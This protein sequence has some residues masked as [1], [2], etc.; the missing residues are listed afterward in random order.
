MRTQPSNFYAVFAAAADRFSDR[1]A[2]E[3]QTTG[4][5]LQVRYGDLK[6]LAESTAGWLVSR[7][8][9][10]GDR[11]AVLADNDAHWCAAY[12]GILRCG[13]VAVPLDTAYTDTQ[14]A[15]LF[16]DCSA[17]A[18][19]TSS[20]YLASVH[21]GATRASIAPCIAVLPPVGHELDDS[22]VAQGGATSFGVVASQAALAFDCPAGRDD[23]AV[24]LYTSGTTSDPKGVVLTHANLLAERE[25]AFRIVSV[26]EADAVLSV[27]PLFHA[28]AQMA[29]LLLPLS[30]GARVVF[31]ETVN[32]TELTRA[33]RERGITAFVCVPQFFYLL[34][35]RIE[36]GI[37][38]LAAPARAAVRML[39]RI[40]LLSRRVGVNAGRVLFRRIHESVGPDL[41]V[42][43]TGGARFDPATNRALHALGFTIQQAYGLTE[44]SGAATVTRQ[45]DL[46]FDSVGLPFPGVELRIGPPDEA[47]ADR[48][49]GEVLIRGPIVMKGYYNRPDE[50][51]RTLVDGWLYTGDLGYLDAN[52]RLYITGRSKE[53]IVLGSGKNI[54]PEEIEAHYEQSVFVHELCVAG[55]ARPGEPS[56]ERLHALIRPDLDAMRARGMVN[57]RELLR[58]EIEGLSVQLPPHKRILGYDITLEPL[59][60]TTTRKLKRFEV[61]RMLR[62]RVDG[63]A[64]GET[65]IS[66][67]DLDP[68]SAR[69]MEEIRDAIRHETPLSPTAHLELDVGLDSMER[70]ELLVH[71]TGVFDVALA[72]GEA[73]TLH[74]V[75]DVVELFRSRITS[76]PGQGT[77]RAPW[78][79][80]LEARLEDNPF[81]AEL[82]KPKRLLSVLL[83]L[84]VKVLRGICAVSIGLRGRGSEHLP[85]SGPYMISPNHQSYVDPFLMAACLP[86]GVFRQLFFV[87]AAEYFETP[88]TRWL[89]RTLNVIPIDPDANL[90]AAMQAGAEGL[91]RG[92]VL[93][94]FPEGERSIDGS[95]K[96]FKKGAAILSSHLGV[97]IVPVAIDGAWTIWARRQP[98]NWRALLPWNR[99]RARVQFGAALPPE[100]PPDYMTV[101]TRLRDRVVEMWEGLNRERSRG[102]R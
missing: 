76:L 21:A 28:L 94:L 31:L 96:T 26:S 7:G 53:V 39:A 23:V 12:L 36:A 97:P 38:Q 6:R 50:N 87:G 84:I 13:A 93:V 34:H 66:I 9:R 24:M 43:V 88:F 71:L 79:R 91:R 59:P 41:R 47:S 54:Y 82:D 95:V 80:L 75:A 61:E 99:T 40:N 89:A 19:F 35:R 20:K 2:I 101:T 65:D 29:N 46:H 68:L 64:R 57:I 15:T 73:Q 98:F 85:A 102:T 90:V 100:P 56:A 32:T 62:V 33:L 63:G 14:I 86:F 67:A 48:S 70:V 51:A 10:P 18:V 49:D 52:G 4:Q 69:V 17:R 77:D 81:V 60:R 30:V 92:K 3:I 55:V 11:V 74:T 78:D 72:D 25:G 27:L 22:S 5:L 1:V 42:L 16:A 83:F 8:V 45:G 37:A 58:F 44:C